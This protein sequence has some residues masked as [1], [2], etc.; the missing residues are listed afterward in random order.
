MKNYFYSIFA[1]MALFSMPFIGFAEGAD[2]TTDKEDNIL[3]EEELDKHIG[4]YGDA[5]DIPEDFE[6]NPAEARLWLTD[7]FAMVKEPVSMYYEFERSGSYD[8]GFIDSVYLKVLKIN[9]DG[10]KN[11]KLD[12]LSGEKKT[13]G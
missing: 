5:E 4:R 11:V 1:S 7:H 10:T 12:F 13:T 9:D 2:N 6:F 8:T 3:T